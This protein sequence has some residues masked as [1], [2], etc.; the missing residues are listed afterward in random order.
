[1]RYWMSY[2]SQ[3]AIS[4]LG[5]YSTEKLLGWSLSSFSPTS[6][7]PDNL[8]FL[9]QGLQIAWGLC[10]RRENESNRGRE[11][12]CVRVNVR[13]CASV[14]GCARRWRW[15]YRIMGCIG[16]NLGS[17]IVNEI[18]HGSNCHSRPNDKQAQMS[19]WKFVAEII[20]GGTFIGLDGELGEAFLPYLP[21]STMVAS[22]V[23]VYST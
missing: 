4:K 2:L 21:T 6:V 20:L 9:P 18:Q 12:V 22:I 10:A 23:S 3:F 5:L 19:W 15:C 14:C 16:F 8:I 17:L 11:S 1:M 13:A 7:E